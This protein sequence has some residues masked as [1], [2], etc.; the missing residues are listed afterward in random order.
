LPPSSPTCTAP[1]AS[2]GAPSRPGWTPYR[3]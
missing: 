2:S 1:Q 3:I